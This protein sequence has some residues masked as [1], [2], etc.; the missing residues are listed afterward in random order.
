MHNATITFRAAWGAG[1]TRRGQSTF[2]VGLLQKPFKLAKGFGFFQQ[3]CIVCLRDTLGL[4]LFVLLYLSASVFSVYKKSILCAKIEQWWNNN[5]NSKRIII[6]CCA[7]TPACLVKRRRIQT[8]TTGIELKVMLREN[9]FRNVF[10]NSL[11]VVP[12]V[13]GARLLF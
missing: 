10:I 8:T 9:R 2:G 1:W 5:N 7:L 6:V 12:G 11:F 13:S 3:V 4:F